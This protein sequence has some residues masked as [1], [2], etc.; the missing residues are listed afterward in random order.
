MADSHDP[1]TGGDPRR[2]VPGHG[3][4]GHPGDRPGE[5]DSWPSP[6]TQPI[7]PAG[8]EGAGGPGGHHD[9]TSA[10]GHGYRTGQDGTPYYGVQDS[11][12]SQG[13]YGATPYD[14]SGTYSG[15]DYTAAGAGSGGAQPPYAGGPGY[16]E[17]P[18]NPYPQ[19]GGTAA[20]PKRKFG[21]GAMVAGMA[22][23]GLLGAGVAVGT[24]AVGAN[25]GST[26]STSSSPVV[27]NDTDSVNEIT[28]AT[29]KASPS[30][31]T[32]SAT[33]GN[34]AGTGSGVILDDQG[35]ILTNTHVVTLDGTTADPTVEVQFS[36][37][38]VVSAEVVGTDPNSDLAVIRVDPS[39]VQLTPATLADSD[40]LN[41]GDTVVAIGAPLGLSGTVTDGI[42]ST[43]N[44]T[45][46]IA[47]SAVPDSTST[48]GRVTRRK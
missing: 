31:V 8:H 3:E 45:I 33:S 38:T 41:V 15:A 7:P 40:S 18:G 25:G 42:I 27:V 6:D 37:G 48:E 12:A 17:H 13:G 14:G 4:H 19:R 5:G 28:G 35:H 44:R 24:G 29:Q 32:I 39:K 2:P 1:R 36:D 43:L 20:A 23:A 21:A 9:G 47:S 16:E 34:Q 46:S 10:G 22:L 26:G 30:V 11:G